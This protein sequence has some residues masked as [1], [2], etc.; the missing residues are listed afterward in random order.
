MKRRAGAKLHSRSH[1]QYSSWSLRRETFQ[2]Q[3][4]SV[5]SP[6]RVCPLTNTHTHTHLPC[7]CVFQHRCPINQGAFKSIE[8]IKRLNLFRYSALIAY[9]T[10]ITHTRAFCDRE[11]L[12]RPDDGIFTVLRWTESQKWQLY[13]QFLHV[14]S[15]PW[16]KPTAAEVTKAQVSSSFSVRDKTWKLF[17]V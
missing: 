15:V 16:E 2:G 14:A 11:R 6:H 17:V 10:I 1:H 4:V 9:Y 5:L 7:S 8:N 3:W 12:R 13:E